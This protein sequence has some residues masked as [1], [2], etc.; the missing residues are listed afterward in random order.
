MAWSLSELAALTGTDVIGDPDCRV[1]RLNSLQ[2]AEPGDLSFLSQVRRRAELQT[3]R[4]SAVVVPP[5]CASETVHGLVS[6]QPYLTYARLSQVMDP[7][8]LPFSGVRDETASIS[9][10]ANLAASVSIAPFA[11]IGADVVIGEG[12]VIGPHVVI[13][14]GTQIGKRCLIG[15]HS[16]IGSDGFGFA[17]SETGWIKIHHL[18][19]VLIG[20]DVEIGAS[21]TIDRGALDDT[22][23]GSGVK[24]DNQIMIAHGCTIGP[25][26]AMAA[27]VALAGST[28]I[29]SDV[30]VGGMT[31]F[32]GHLEVCDRVHI[33]AQALVTQSITTPGHYAGGA[34]GVMPV[35]QWRRNAVRFRQLD[36]LATRLAH[37]E[38]P[39][40]S[41]N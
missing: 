7:R 2:A 38:K 33:G 3:T 1:S 37:L 24:L 30:T 31:G 29:G 8:G 21:C 4:A 32:T 10:S 18:G 17:P 25:R 6:D 12:S 5:Q 16:V 34:A 27:C 11:V 9:A 22:V 15:A 35:A 26:T 36:R 23:I 13:Y 41:T 40:D 19:R 28:H 39:N 14:P 20:D